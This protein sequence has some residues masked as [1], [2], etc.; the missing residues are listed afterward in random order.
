VE[1]ADY[2]HEKGVYVRLKG[3][4]PKLIYSYPRRGNSLKWRFQVSGNMIMDFG[5]VAGSMKTD[6]RVLYESS[7]ADADSIRMGAHETGTAGGNL[8]H[9]IPVVNHDVGMRSHCSYFI[10]RLSFF[11]P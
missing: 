9:R 4:G 1:R 11:T 10:G 8:P 2:E 7:R 6:D 5:V 3:M